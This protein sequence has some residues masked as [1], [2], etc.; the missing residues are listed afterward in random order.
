MFLWLPAERSINVLWTNIQ[1]MMH[2]ISNQLSSS[3]C[4]GWI[5]YYQGLF[6]ILLIGTALNKRVFIASIDFKCISS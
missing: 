4:L 1:W 2:T 6:T 5:S 3:Y